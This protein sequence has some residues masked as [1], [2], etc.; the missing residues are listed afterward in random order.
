MQAT[1]WVIAFTMFGLM[2]FC[3]SALY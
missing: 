3:S 1:I 2:E